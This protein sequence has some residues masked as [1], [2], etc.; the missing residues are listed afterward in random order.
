MAEYYFCQKAQCIIVIKKK[1]LKEQ[2]ARGLLSN[3]TGTKVP[4]LRNTSILNTFFKYKM[5]ERVNNLLLAGDK[6]I[7]E[8]HLK[9]PGFIIKVFVD[10]S[11]KIKKEERN[12]KK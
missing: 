12:L 6:F 9:L 2:V 1:S 8:I 7:P 11:I 3:L 4:F 5:K 10:H